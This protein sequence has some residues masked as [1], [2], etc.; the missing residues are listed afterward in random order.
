[1]L[2]REGQFQQVEA[3]ALMGL[4]QLALAEGQLADAEVA[5]RRAGEIAQETDDLEGRLYALLHLG[6]VQER[7]QSLAEA[8]ATL[9]LALTL[10]REVGHPKAVCDVHR[11]LYPMYARK[12]DHA[13]ALAHLEQLYQQEREILNA[14][15][16][17]RV[18][19]LTSQFELERAQHQAELTRL[20]LV[21]AE[22][23]REVAEAEVRERTLSLEQAQLE[24]V[25]RLAVAA[26]YRDDTTGEHTWRVGQVA[27]AIALQ[28]GLP[29]ETADLLR[30]A[31][32]LHDVGKIGI[33][34]RILLKTGQLSDEEFQYMQRHTL[35]GSRILS[36]GQTR[37][38]QMAEEIACSHHERWGGG[39]YPANLCGEAIPLTARIVAV[40]DVFDALTHDRPYKA[41]WTIAQALQELQNLSGTLFDPA[42]VAAALQVLPLAGL[43]RPL[44]DEVGPKLGL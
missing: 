18:Q 42:V 6:E 32:R 1:M 23:A 3:S 34:D 11:S 19:A 5:Y 21:A 30:V 36:G 35:I 12:G 37:L 17:E 40:A 39:G 28:L 41:A 9:E 31:A 16:E 24:V 38:L 22:E 43:V 13:Q 26:E 25:T 29:E 10:A 33:P 20:R 4:G 15:V 14:E 27:A 8:L 7:L 2:A 44:P